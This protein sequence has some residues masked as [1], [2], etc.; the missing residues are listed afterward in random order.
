MVATPNQ[1]F[2]QLLSQLWVLGLYVCT[3]TDLLLL[4]MWRIAT[5]IPGF[6]HHRLRMLKGPQRSLIEHYQGPA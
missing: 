6:S 5:P 2:N 4:P 1:P 3:W